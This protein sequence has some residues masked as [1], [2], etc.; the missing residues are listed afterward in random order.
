MT[1][2]RKIGFNQVRSDV[3]I[4][5]GGLNEAV[6]SLEMR[7]GELLNV[8]NYY[9]TETVT[10]GYTSAKG[11]ERYD[12][13]T[14][15]SSIAASDANHTAQDAARA[16]IDEIPGEGN[17][18]GLFYYKDKLYAFRNKTGGATAGMYVESATGWVEVST[19]AAPLAPSGK[20]AS[21][22]YNFLATSGN[23]VV[24]WVDGVNGA[25]MFNGTTITVIATGMGTADK[26]THVAVH[27]D[28]LFLS[29]LGGSLQ[30]SNV[31]DPTDWTAGSG[32]IGIGYDITSIK[33]NVGG[34]L[35]IN[36]LNSIKILEGESETTWVL[37]TFSESLGAFPYTV[38]KLFD[39]V[40]FMSSMGLSTLSASQEFG[41]FASSS[42][43]PKVAKTLL[44]NKNYA[45]CSV[46]SR[47][48]NQYRLFF[49]NNLCLVFSFIG[50]KLKGITRLAYGMPVYNVIECRNTSGDNLIFFT[51]NTGY[52]YQMDIGTSYDGV[53]IKSRFSTAYHNYKSP[54]NLKRF[55]KLTFEVQAT[56]PL[57]LTMRP[58]FDYSEVGV[59]KAIT[60]TFDIDGVGN[61]YGEGLWGTMLFG[62]T[63][64]TNRVGVNMNGIASNLSVTI[65]AESAYNTQHTVQNFITDYEVLGIQA[66]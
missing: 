46:V 1:T 53:S 11:F 59:P 35:V 57:S 66:S 47:D 52:A 37:K 29:F 31:G 64:A 25:R 28:R 61:L 42:I 40:I 7:S 60:D 14:K 2:P 22:L 38:D 23:E 8:R 12:G 16:A 58:S 17:P 43:S 63:D 41:G 48:L 4:L 32:E 21:V 54:R 27:Q 49:T 51:S 15:P 65:L 26:P 55:H 18:L 24:I 33:A 6:S 39:T 30:Y 34:T 44:R 20:V 3:V 56:T 62:G 13:N 5:D 36:T 45:S 19:S 50:K 9:V 10:G